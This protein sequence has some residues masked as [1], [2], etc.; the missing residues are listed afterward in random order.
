M[1]LLLLNVA[2]APP[3]V[4]IRRYLRVVPSVVAVAEEG[5]DADNQT[6]HHKQ[7]QGHQEK[8]STQG[9]PRATPNEQD[10][11]LLHPP[12]DAKRACCSN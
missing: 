3:R 12:A 4:G 8:P 9:D 10:K 7:G 5:E 11:E 6:H 1:L 2:L